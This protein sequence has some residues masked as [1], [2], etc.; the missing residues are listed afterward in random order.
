LNRVPRSPV[1]LPTALPLNLGEIVV[2]YP[3]GHQFLRADQ[4]ALAIIQDS[5]NDRPIYFASTG[6]MARDLGLQP[7]VVRQGL[8]SKLW[9]EDPENSPGIVRVSDAVGGEW[10]D[11][12][13]TLHLAD[14]VFTY[15]GLENRAIWADRATLNIPWHFYYMHVQLADAAIRARGDRELADRLMSRADRFGVTATGGSR[16][17][18]GGGGSVVVA[19][20]PE[21]VEVGSGS[22]TADLPDLSEDSAG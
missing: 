10:V 16:A 5:M 1:A 17:Q 4:I 8:A 21:A 13:R 18:E 14:E 12:E 15:R 6:G 9:S 11:F 2:Q 7:W 20:D 22:G 3:A 19:E